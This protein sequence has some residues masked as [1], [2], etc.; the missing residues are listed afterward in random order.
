MNRGINFWRAKI[1]THGIY[2]LGNPVIW[3]PGF[4]SVV[5]YL[6]YVG[7]DFVLSQRK[8]NMQL[9]GYGEMIYNSMAVFSTGY[10]LHY[11]PF[12]LM[13]RQLFLHHYLPALYFSI[14]SLGG[15]FEFMTHKF[16]KISW[17]F[18]LIRIFALVFASI[19]IY[20]F[21]LFSPLTYGLE[22]PRQNCLELKWNSNWDFKCPSLE[23]PLPRAEPKN[24]KKI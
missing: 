23:N 17:L 11:V 14:L 21:V 7:I 12:F 1:D 9:N 6:A 8:S 15:M 10:L 19:A 13:Q 18:L 5:F 24:P 22:Q 4:F 16:K 3:I 20:V 2:L